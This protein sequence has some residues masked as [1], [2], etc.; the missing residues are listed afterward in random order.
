MKKLAYAFDHGNDLDDHEWIA[1]KITSAAFFKDYKID[2]AQAWLVFVS[3]A[4]TVGAKWL[5]E[6]DTAAIVAAIEARTTVVDDTPRGG[7]LRQE[8]AEVVEAYA[9]PMRKAA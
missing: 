3:I 6:A 7:H 1:K 5:A 9:E 4:Q 2:E 8:A